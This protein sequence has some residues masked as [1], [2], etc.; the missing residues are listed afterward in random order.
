M[1]MTKSRGRCAESSRSQNSNN[2]EIDPLNQI[3]INKIQIYDWV[4]NI[5]DE[6]KK[7]SRIKQMQKFKQR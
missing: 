7:W 3:P 4:Y 2:A 5:D 6:S 1:Y